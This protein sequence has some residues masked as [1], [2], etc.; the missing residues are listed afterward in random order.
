[1]SVIMTAASVIPAILMWVWIYLVFMVW[2]KKTNIFHDQ[3]EPKLAERRYKML[4]AFLLVAGISFA[5]FFVCLALYKT[6]EPVYLYIG[7]VGIS[8]GIIATVGGLVI[9]LKGRRETR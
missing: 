4:K 7:S 1:M 8:V 6:E 9:F 2:K 5:V 3:M